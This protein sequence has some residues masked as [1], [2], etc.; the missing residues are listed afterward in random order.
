MQFLQRDT[1]LADC[2]IFVQVIPPQIGT[3]KIIISSCKYTAVR[4][5]YYNQTPSNLAPGISNIWLCSNVEHT[6]LFVKVAGFS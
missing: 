6:V 3:L 1:V 2:S 5:K 4:M